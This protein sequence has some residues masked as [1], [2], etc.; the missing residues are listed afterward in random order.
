LGQLCVVPEPVPGDVDGEVP[1]SGE[2]DGDGD[3][4]AW[5]A[6]S[7]PNPIAKPRPPAAT[8]LAI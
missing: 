8:N 1:T 2:T 5:A 6:T 7:V 3:V 4:A